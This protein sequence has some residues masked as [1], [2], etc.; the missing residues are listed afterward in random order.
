VLLFLLHGGL[1]WILVPHPC[2]RTLASSYTNICH[3]RSASLYVGCM[4]LLIFYLYRNCC[5]NPGL[6]RI[7][8]TG[9]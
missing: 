3:N 4:K 6:G 2:F 8:S 1:R 7:V 9:H 5:R